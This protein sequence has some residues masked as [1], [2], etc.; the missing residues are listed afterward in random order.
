LEEKKVSKKKKKG[1]K[2]PE[3]KQQTK[4]TLEQNAGNELSWLDQQVRRSHG[5]KKQRPEK[6]TKK[7]TVGK[8]KK[9]GR[10]KG[11]KS[12]GKGG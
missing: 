3:G 6:N 9:R 10:K 4:R 1:S 2:V 11:K 12:S 7:E 8:K 5:V